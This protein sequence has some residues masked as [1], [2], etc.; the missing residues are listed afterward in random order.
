MKLRVLP[1]LTPNCI[2]FLNNL[3]KWLPASTSPAKLNIL[4]VGGGNSSLYFL[5]KGCK[6][7]TIESD[8]NFI[9]VLRN[10]ATAVGFS[11]DICTANNQTSFIDQSSADLKIIKATNISEIEKSVL[12]KDYDIFI[13]DGISRH[14]FLE[15]YII[16]KMKSI[17]ILDNCEYCANCGYLSLSSAYP[18]RIKS[19]RKFLRSSSHKHYLFEQ[20]EGRDGHGIPDATGSEITG[21]WISAITWPNDS[22][23]AKYI[24]TDL[25]LPMVIKDG[26]NDSDIST[27]REKNPYLPELSDKFI[28][29]HQ[30]SRDYE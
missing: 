25:G 4:E 18:E 27:V 2:N 30:N 11:V 7:V 3:F 15:F 22:K 16:N 14:E 21:R 24:V 8:D 1:W 19:Y 23:F 26:L 9:E 10:A 13:N 17:L 6:I 29:S 20:I 28:N 5:S 12:L